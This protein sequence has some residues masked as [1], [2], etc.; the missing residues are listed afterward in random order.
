MTKGNHTLRFISL[1]ALLLMGAV[2]SLASAQQE[3]SVGGYPYADLLATP[4]WLRQQAD[5]DDLVIVDVRTDEHFDGRVIPGAVRMP[6]AAF[7]YNNTAANEGSL[8]VGV[9]R[10]QEILGQH[11]IGRT[12]TIVL[13]DSV[14]RDGGA[15]ASYLFWVLDILGHENKRVLEGGIDA[16]ASA[17]YELDSKP[18]QLSPI[19][20]QAPMAEI[21]GRE[22]IDGDDVYRNL[23]DPHYQII[24]VRSPAEYKGEKGTRDLQ[25][26]GLKLGHIPTAVNINYTANWRDSETKHIKP[27]GAL[28]ELYRGLDTSKDIIVYCNSGR[29]SSS[30][31]FVLR[32]MGIDNVTTY[33]PSWKQWGNPANFDPV[34]TTENQLVGDTLPGTGSARTATTSTTRSQSS[35]QTETSDGNAPKGG[36][37]SCGG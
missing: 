14:A 8:F 29:R 5:D 35:G 24:D 27:Y 36:Y 17:G 9:A 6:W 23:G 13:Y 22:I 3:Q 28:Q 25:G 32:L 11:G 10:A 26:N 12:H 34:E 15:T 4:Q 37:V 16:W 33:E 1:A 20:Y 7:R 2:W 31:Y 18:R 21:R 19:L 30:S